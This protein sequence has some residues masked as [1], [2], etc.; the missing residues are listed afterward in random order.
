MDINNNIAIDIFYLLTFN[1]AA[2]VLFVAVL[3]L[4]FE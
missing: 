1:Y 4:L 3:L 2:V